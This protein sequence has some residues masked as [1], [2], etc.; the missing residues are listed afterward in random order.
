MAWAVALTRLTATSREPGAGGCP[1]RPAF[2]DTL[3][4]VLTVRIKGFWT[5]HCH[6]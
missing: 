5:Q 6:C 2:V 1:L 4:G 3:G